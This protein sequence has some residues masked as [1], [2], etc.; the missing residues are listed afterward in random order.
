VHVRF[1]DGE[2][3][4]RGVGV[5][6]HWVYRFVSAPIIGSPRGGS[7]PAGPR[8]C[9]ISMGVVYSWALRKFVRTS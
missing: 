7:Y 2:P 8:I 4:G 6:G 9:V 5:G 1:D 3:V